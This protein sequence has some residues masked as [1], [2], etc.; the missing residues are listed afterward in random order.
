MRMR[1]RRA[2]LE[3][4]R[5]ERNILVLGGGDQDNLGEPRQ[6]GFLGELVQEGTVEVWLCIVAAVSRLRGRGGC[7][8]TTSSLGITRGGGGS[9]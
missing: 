5:V 8:C 3:T 9:R 4:S 1:G 6:T 7:R 2:Y